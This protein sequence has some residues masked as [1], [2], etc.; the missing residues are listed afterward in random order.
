[1]EALGARVGVE[2]QAEAVGVG[3]DLGVPAR[4]EAVE[5]GADGDRD[6]ALVA[7]GVR[8][9]RGVCLRREVRRAAA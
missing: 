5:G 7:V 4:V 6:E 3:R 2:A 1:V 9:G 8:G